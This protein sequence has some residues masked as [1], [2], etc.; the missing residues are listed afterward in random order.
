M[1]ADAAPCWSSS[2]MRVAI[3]TSELSPRM[4][5]TAEVRRL[6]HLPAPVATVHD[7]EMVAQA[8][9]H[10]FDRLV[11]ALEGEVEDQELRLMRAITALRIPPTLVYSRAPVASVRRWAG[12]SAARNLIVRKPPIQ[13]PQLVR[14][15]S[16]I[17]VLPRRFGEGRTA[18]FGNVF[19]D[20]VDG[21]VRVGDRALSMQRLEFDLALLLF[22][23]SMRV[24]S[25]EVIDSV[26]GREYSTGQRDA[27]TQLIARIRRWLIPEIAGFA[28][29]DVPKVGYV[30]VDLQ[31][32][33]RTS[34]GILLL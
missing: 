16:Q 7:L 14:N 2:P 8:H 29:H 12:A 9:P 22:R 3:L 34:A 32:A 19:F 31:A 23:N 10:R 6:G 13:R 18:R 15:L 4:E 33:H 26:V 5:I 17:G 30:M 25:S 11:I 27:A 20:G 1:A 28:L 24:V 21:V